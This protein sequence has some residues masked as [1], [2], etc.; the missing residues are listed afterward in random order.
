MSELWKRKEVIGDCT[1]YLGD[2][3][4]IL[5]TLEKVDAVITDPPYGIGLGNHAGAKD[6]RSG[7]LGKQ[8]YETY[9][10]T[11]ENFISVVVPAIE[12]SL[13]KATRG[14]VYCFASCGMYLPKPRALGGVYIPAACGRSSW[15]YTN[16]APLYLYGVSPTIHKGASHTVFRS[17]AVADKNEHPCPKPVEWMNWIVGMASLANE[18]IIDPFMGSGTT[19]VACANLGR[20][21][22]GVEIEEKYFNIACERITNAYRQQKLF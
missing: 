9:E 20:K 8:E 17:S 22:I 12:I 18:T 15:G 4:E 7:Y 1:L 5:P 3:L 19:G 2:C 21:F 11:E 14:A 10:D 6:V 16:F 13:S